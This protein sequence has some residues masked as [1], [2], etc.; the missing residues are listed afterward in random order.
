MAPPVRT[1]PDPSDGSATCITSALISVASR[2]AR[3]VMSPSMLSNLV[4][5][6]R[7]GKGKAHKPF[8]FGVKSAV[9]VTRTSKA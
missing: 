2:V 3:C 9:V 6:K 7:I 5:S 8:E 4:K 1:R